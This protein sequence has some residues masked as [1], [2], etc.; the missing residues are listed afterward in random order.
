[1]DKYISRFIE[2]VKEKITIPSKPIFTEIKIWVLSDNSYFVHWFWHMKEDGLQGIN[3][4][5]KPL[6]RNRI[7]I[8]VILILLSSPSGSSWYI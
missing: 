3:K 4:V 7:I 5:S 1:M 8:A 2:R 6:G